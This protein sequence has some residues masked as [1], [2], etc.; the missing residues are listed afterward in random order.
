[1]VINMIASPGQE[2]LSTSWWRTASHNRPAPPVRAAQVQVRSEA[3]PRLRKWP[4]NSSE[5]GVSDKLMK[6][7]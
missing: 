7:S 2:P 4:E 6:K 3:L 1:M 5:N